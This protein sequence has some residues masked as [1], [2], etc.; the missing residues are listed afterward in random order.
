MQFLF[1][2]GNIS[3]C[4]VAVELL[5]SVEIENSYVLAD[6]AYGTE[7]IR[8]YIQGKGAAYVIPLKVNT[9]DP[10][11]CDYYHYKER[12]VVE[13]FFQKIKQFRRVATRYEKLIQCFKAVVYLASIFVLVK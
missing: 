1:T 7:K 10:W 11:D 12:H 2:G 3:D 5:S 6:K 13:C 8:T 9:V 4:S